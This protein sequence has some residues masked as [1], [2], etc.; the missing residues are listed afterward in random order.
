MTKLTITH[1][2]FT[3]ELFHSKKINMP[4]LAYAGALDEHIFHDV[5]L[6]TI[7]HI[8][9]QDFHVSYQAEEG[10][11]CDA[12]NQPSK[13]LEILDNGYIYQVVESYS[14]PNNEEAKAE[15][16]ACDEFTNF[17]DATQIYDYITATFYPAAESAYRNLIEN[18]QDEIKE[19]LDAQENN[20]A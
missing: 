16:E 10:S 1:D 14:D 3:S 11:Y 19:H 15:L 17:D 8:N 6:D 9:S 18:S 12:N 5:S 7:L 4:A 13:N 20:H 2:A